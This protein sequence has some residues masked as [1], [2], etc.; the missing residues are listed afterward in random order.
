MTVVGLQSDVLKLTDER[1]GNLAG[2]R[3][4]DRGT[5]QDYLSTAHVLS[6]LAGLPAEVGVA[7]SFGIALYINEAARDITSFLLGHCTI[8]DLDGYLVDFLDRLA[9]PADLLELELEGAIDELI[10]LRSEYAQAT[11]RDTRG[12]LGEEIGSVSR[13][14]LMLERARGEVRKGSSTTSPASGSLEGA[15][16]GAASRID[17]IRKA[18][19]SEEATLKELGDRPEV[20]QPSEV[21][22]EGRFGGDPMTAVEPEQAFPETSDAA[23]VKMLGDLAGHVRAESAQVDALHAKVI[24]N[25]HPPTFETFGEV[26]NRWFAFFSP[27]TREADP[28]YRQMDRLYS[29]LWQALGIAGVE[30]GLGRMMIMESLGAN[31]ARWIGGAQSDFAS[32]LGTGT[33]ERRQKTLGGTAASP[34]FVYAETYGRT[35]TPGFGP[36]AETAS[37]NKLLTMRGLETQGQ[38]E[39]IQR[40]GQ[41]AKRLRRRRSSASSPRQRRECSSC[42]RSGPA[43][44]GAT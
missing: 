31:A 4:I 35:N 27:A 11:D 34:D 15:L 5:K 23:S 41:G 32:E 12:A 37:R 44:L 33:P 8:D 6:R 25:Q 18:A 43:M 28:F 19:E 13:R 36:G 1:L 30:G 7:V 21:V 20:L 26:Y 16:S 9:G 40:A 29:T 42:N 2:V 24:P 14:V 3:V 38:F 39:Q 17:A 22:T 10:R